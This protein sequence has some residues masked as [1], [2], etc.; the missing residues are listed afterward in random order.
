MEPFPIFHSFGSNVP[1]QAG[2]RKFGVY[3]FIENGRVS[4]YI[5]L[6]SLLRG[7]YSSFHRSCLGFPPSTLIYNP[8]EIS[9]QV[10]LFLCASFRGFDDWLEKINN[11]WSACANHWLSCLAAIGANKRPF[12]APP[13]PPP[14]PCLPWRIL[15]FTT[16]VSTETSVPGTEENHSTLKGKIYTFFPLSPSVFLSFL[17]QKVGLYSYVCTLFSFA[18]HRSIPNIQ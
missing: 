11:R 9:G 14:P 3:L 7:F 2:M 18:P 8:L 1:R 4:V 6:H 12:N 13:R 5:L 15:Y 16:S 10:F 17:R